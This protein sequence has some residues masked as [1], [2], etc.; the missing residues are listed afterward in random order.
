MSRV[1]RSCPNHPV[2]PLLLRHTNAA[3]G[4]FDAADHSLVVAARQS[5]STS[6]LSP[7]RR[8]SFLC[9]PVFLRSPLF[10]RHQS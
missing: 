10:P 5:P 9:L 2:S 7:R 8:P 6:P 4:S 1:A 3:I